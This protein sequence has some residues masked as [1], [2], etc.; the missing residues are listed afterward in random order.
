MFVIIVGNVTFVENVEGE[1]EEEG[2]VAVLVE[3]ELE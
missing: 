2:D 3:L 1:E